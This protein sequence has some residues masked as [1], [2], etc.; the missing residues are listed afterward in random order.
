MIH[1]SCSCSCSCPC[2]LT[3]TV[4]RPPTTTTIGSV[5]GFDTVWRVGEGVGERRKA[6]GK[7][8]YT[9]VMAKT[10]REEPAGSKRQSAK[11]VTIISRPKRSSCLHICPTVLSALCAYQLQLQVTATGPSYDYGYKPPA[12]VAVGTSTTLREVGNFKPWIRIR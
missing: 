9:I 4:K 6:K 2:V 1:D 7:G 5:T 3:C 11:M 8:V 12:A 10:E